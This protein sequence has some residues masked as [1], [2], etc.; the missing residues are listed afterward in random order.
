MKI[1]F[2]NLSKPR[3]FNYKPFFYDA[4]KDELEQRIKA[5]KFTEEQ[6]EEERI[7]IR[8]RSNF[9]RQR[10]KQKAKKQNWTRLIIMIALAGLIMYI[11]IR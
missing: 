1:S 4:Q 6:S 9:E 5:H 7:K 2:F 10:G 11:I 8:L 3:Q